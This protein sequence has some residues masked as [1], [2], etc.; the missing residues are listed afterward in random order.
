MLT[1]Y[2]QLNKSAFSLTNTINSRIIYRIDNRIMK[3]T[4]IIDDNIIQEALK[5]SRAKTV[6]DALKVAL[7]KYVSI[8][9]LKELG[10]KVKDNPLKFQHSADQIREINREK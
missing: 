4:A 10:R 5:Y 8:Q 2:V 6:T 3:V 9:K 1:G 7:R